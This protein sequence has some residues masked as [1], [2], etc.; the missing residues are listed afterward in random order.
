[1][2]IDNFVPHESATYAEQA[3]REVLRPGASEVTAVFASIE[4]VAVEL[5]RKLEEGGVDVPGEMAVAAFN[6]REHFADGRRR[7]TT[8]RIP[9]EE[10]AAEAMRMLVAQVRGEEPFPQQRV[11]SGRLVVREST[12]RNIL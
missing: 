11:L 9:M 8:V 3:I 2:F 1:M 5:L 12:V 4:S 10:T 7:L 6:D